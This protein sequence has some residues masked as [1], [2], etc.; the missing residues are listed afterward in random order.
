MFLHLSKDKQVIHEINVWIY[1]VK[2]KL[3]YWKQNESKHG[4]KSENLVK[5]VSNE[6]FVMKIKKFKVSS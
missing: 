2:I 1:K 3:K 5:H 4:T 6:L